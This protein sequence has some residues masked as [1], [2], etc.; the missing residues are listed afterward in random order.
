MRT[1]LTLAAVFVVE[2]LFVFDAANAGPC[3]DQIS[4]IEHVMQ[5]PKCGRWLSRRLLHNCIISQHRNPSRTPPRRDERKSARYWRAQKLSTRKAV[6][7][8]A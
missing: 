8:G 6:P 4:Q 7:P 2:P 5:Q 3:T 1:I